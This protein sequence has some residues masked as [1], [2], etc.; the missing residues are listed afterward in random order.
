[1]TWV[2]QVSWEGIA[3]ISGMRKRMGVFV[4]VIAGL[5]ALGMIIPMLFSGSSPGGAAA[6]L[7]VAKVNRERVSALDLNR[8]FYRLYYYRTSFGGLKAEDLDALRSQALD[9]LLEQ[10]IILDAAK[11][12]GLKPNQ[13]QVEAAYKA[14]LG[15]FKSEQEFIQAMSGWAYTPKTYKQELGKR[16]LIDK[17][18]LYAKPVE[19]TEDDVNAE[20][21]RA[22]KTN[23]KLT[24]DEARESIEK[25]VRARKEKEARDSLLAE[26][27]EK[28]KIKIIDSQVLA[29]RA[30]QDEKFDEAVKLYK[31]AIKQSPEDPY[32]QVSLG[33]ALAAAGK[34]NDSKAAFEK[35]V[36][37]RAD[38]RFILIA[39]ADSLK[40]AGETDAAADVY[41]HAAQVAGEDLF[42]HGLI[43]D[44]FEEMGLEDDAQAQKGKIDA[45]QK[46][47]VERYEAQQ[48]AAEDGQDTE[49]AVG[50]E[51]SQE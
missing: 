15:Y 38:D 23:P 32:L 3:L 25:L 4:A 33:R 30:M 24:L 5:L 8:E 16:Q 27:R 35:A 31:K 1:M 48:K 26:L 46:A 9:S 34:G 41:R 17:Y 21:E 43:L 10:A 51:N 40:D 20:F 19:V 49:D 29:Y 18:P 36:K 50:A 13:E 2:I 37:L 42:A 12:A 28:A 11:S 44:A 39:Q 14:E 7:T 47:L 45:L 6:R 22:Q